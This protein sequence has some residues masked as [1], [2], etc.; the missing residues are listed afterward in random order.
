MAARQLGQIA[1]QSPAH[2]DDENLCIG[3]SDEFAD[4]AAA[5]AAVIVLAV[6]D[7][8]ESLFGVLSALELGQPKV[9]RVVQGGGTF[10]GLEG[11][12]ISKSL[13]IGGETLRDFCAICEFN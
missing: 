4:V 6:G 11:E 12:A 13:D 5:V 1:K 7:Q 10:S 3:L 9:D 8:Q 2:I